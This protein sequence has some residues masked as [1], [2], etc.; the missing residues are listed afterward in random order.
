LLFGFL[1]KC[2]LPSGICPSLKSGRNP[3]CCKDSCI[4]RS[5]LCC[6]KCRHAHC[7]ACRSKVPASSFCSWIVP[8]HRCRSSFR[9]RG[10]SICQSFCY[11]NGSKAPYIGHQ[12]PKATAASASE[13][14]Q[15]PVAGLS[16]QK[17]QHRRRIGTHQPFGLGHW[18][19]L[20]TLHDDASL[21][22][23]D[24]E[25]QRPAHHQ[26]EAAV[27][28]P[29]EAHRHDADP[30]RV[31]CRSQVAERGTLAFCGGTPGMLPSLCLAMRGRDCL[32]GN[33]FHCPPRGVCARP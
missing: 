1:M 2:L 30:A 11:L 3:L 28:R 32:P 4:P 8:G 5:S 31:V 12:M 23:L 16:P 29:G 6:V 7:T 18:A 33:S 19:F 9:I 22:Q 13:Q 10:E 20:H 17:L 26:G 14:P 27:R 21:P 25:A 15:L 24:R